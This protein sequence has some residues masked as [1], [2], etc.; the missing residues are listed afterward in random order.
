MTRECARHHVAWLAVCSVLMAACGD[1][2]EEPESAP[3]GSQ[4]GD[5]PEPPPSAPEAG[6]S[7]APSTPPESPS[8]PAPQQPSGET[9][10][11]PANMPAPAG[12]PAG[13]PAA[14]APD[15]TA[16]APEC[17]MTIPKT[18]TC[19]EVECPAV[20]DE[21]A[22]GLCIV[23][24]CT[25]DD[26]CGTR[27]ATANDP[28][29]CLVP[30]VA[31]PACPAY[32]GDALGMEVELEGCCAESGFCGAISTLSNACITS[33]TVLADLMPGDPCGDNPGML[34]GGLLDGGLDSGLDGDLDGGLDAGFDGDD[35]GFDGG[36]DAGVDAGLDIEPDASITDAEVDIE[37]AD[38]CPDITPTSLLGLTTLAGCC[39]DSE[40]CGGISP[41]T[42]ECITTSTLI[43]DLQPGAPC[44]P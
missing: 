14:G 8:A 32:S 9:A 19:G 15:L 24:C 30:A 23:P 25:A 42:N 29:E 21:L 35:A 1:S 26:S 38:S 3:S 4:A 12:A 44:T 10:G 34:D 18:A 11:Q 13:A 40:R 17:D 27:Y 43:L 37:P 6:S 22:S 20:T 39:A 36:L 5:P 7:G 33:S 31:D 2:E 28:T 16:L 41:L